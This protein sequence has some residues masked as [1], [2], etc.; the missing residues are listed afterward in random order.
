MAMTLDGRCIGGPMGELVAGMQARVLANMIGR[1]QD[2]AILDV[3]TGTGRAA[4]MLA[5]GGANVTAVDASE[6]MLEVARRRA[7]RQRVS[8]RFMAG[9]AHALDFKDRAFDV[10]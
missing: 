8:V 9:D 7:E 2:R 6:A 4:L 5:R 10:A 3:G 1:I